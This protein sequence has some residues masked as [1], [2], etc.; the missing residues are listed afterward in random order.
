M[1][2][3]EYSELEKTLDD[4][5][6]RYDMDIMVDDYYNF[7]EE[8]E[9]LENVED[10]SLYMEFDGIYEELCYD[11]EL[12]NELMESGLASTSNLMVYVCTVWAKF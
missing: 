8:I 5:L 10:H 4:I 1:K 12:H 7:T 6:T 9:E 2:I 11:F 3:K